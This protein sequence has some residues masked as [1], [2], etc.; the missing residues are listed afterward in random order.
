MKVSRVTRKIS[1]LVQIIAKVKGQ[2]FDAVDAGERIFWV[3][4]V[5]QNKACQEG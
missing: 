1:E 4:E 3:I 2:F 5:A